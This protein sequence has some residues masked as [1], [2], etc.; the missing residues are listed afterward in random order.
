MT[1]GL[2][3]QHL[4]DPGVRAEMLT[5]WQAERLELDALPDGRNCYGRRL[6]DAGWEAF[7]RAMPE[8]IAYYDDEWLAREMSSPAYWRPFDLRRRRNGGASHVNYNKADALAQLANGEFNVAYIHGLARTLQ[9]SGDTHCMVIRAGGA[10]E[11]RAECSS[12]ENTMVPLQQVIAGHRARYWPRPGNPTAWSLPSG[13]SCHHT[14][15]AVMPP[16]P[17]PPSLT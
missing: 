14:I 17:A 2:T 10:A 5:R 4:D 3:Y 15:R 13:P 7:G 16:D 9:A 12:W 8:A 11:P 6:T 1:T